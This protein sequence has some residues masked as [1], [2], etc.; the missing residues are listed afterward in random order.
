[1]DLCSFI[2]REHQRTWPFDSRLQ[3]SSL[4]GGFVLASEEFGRMFDRLRFYLS[5]YLFIYLFEVQI[6][7]RTLIPVFGPFSVHSGSAS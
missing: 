3:R 5:I 2:Q 7:S 6:R 1:M 4:G